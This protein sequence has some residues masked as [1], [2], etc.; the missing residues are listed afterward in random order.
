MIKYNEI[1]VKVPGLIG[2]TIEAALNDDAVKTRI[3]LPDGGMVAK[4]N[5]E[6]VKLDE[7]VIQSGGDAIELFDSE[8]QVFC[9]ANV[10]SYPAVGRTIGELREDSELT[11]LL[12]VSED[13]EVAINGETP[14]DD[15][16]YVIQ[17]GDRVEFYKAGGRK[18]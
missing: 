13:A 17:V 7:Y 4:A 8:V 5:G 14:E 15:D 16:E 12:G 1:S 9:G 10:E 18:G 2:K 6:F 3:E 11:T